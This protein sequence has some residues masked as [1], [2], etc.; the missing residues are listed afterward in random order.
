[1]DDF[2]WGNTRYACVLVRW[3]E[4]DILSQVVGEG[5]NK[6][7]IYEDD[8]PFTDSMIPYKSFKGA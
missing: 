5:N 4:A 6:T 3:V 1:M 2:S 7:V 8:E